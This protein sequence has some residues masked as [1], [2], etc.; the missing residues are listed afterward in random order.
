MTK[1]SMKNNN[2]NIKLKRLPQI[3]N[4]EMLSIEHLDSII[5]LAKNINLQIPFDILNIILSEY[6]KPLFIANFNNVR[7]HMD[8]QNWTNNNKNTNDSGMF[9]VETTHYQSIIASQFLFLL[10]S[11]I[12]LSCYII[13]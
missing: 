9:V 11:H 10:F 7:S 1:D 2:K 3:K 4:N 12:L 6:T 8:N 13:I 5:K